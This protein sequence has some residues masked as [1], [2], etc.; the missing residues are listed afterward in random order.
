MF[1][2]LI[3][4]PDRRYSQQVK[5]SFHISMAALDLETA[6]DQPAQVMCGY[7]GRNYLL[8]TLKA[9]NLVQCRLDLEFLAGSEVSFV[10]NGKG[11]IHLTGYLTD[12]DN[13]DGLTLE[14]LEEQSEEEEEE[15]EA[16]VEEEIVETKSKKKRKK[17]KQTAEIPS[18]KSKLSNGQPKEQQVEETIEEEEDDSDYVF[19]ET[20]GTDEADID[21]EDESTDDVEEEIEEEE[22]EQVVIS[23]KK[24]K[25]K[26]KKNGDIEQNV[27]KEEPQ[28]KTKKQ[29]LKGGVIIEDLVVGNG[30]PA[31]PGRFVTVYYEG[32]LD[33]NNK[34]FDST[35]KGPGFKFRLGVGEVIKGW[36]IGVAGMKVGGKRKI[37]CPPSTAYGPKGAP[38]SIPPNSTLIFIVTL[39]KIK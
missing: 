3:M 4:E 26:K 14:D 32:R 2:G 6:D 12:V 34:M 22:I 20:S 29:V 17:Q 10:L 38:P 36:D 19:E 25:E 39:R 16:A 8:C 31:K 15:E 33:K 30:P 5:K 21:S 24:E 11:V 23:S 35:V 13:E 1:W 7:D 27:K 28:S 37:I 9:P 18:K